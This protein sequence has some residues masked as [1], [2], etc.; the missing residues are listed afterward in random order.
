MLNDIILSSA[1]ELVRA[2]SN[3][4]SLLRRACESG[5]DCT[6]LAVR[7]KAGVKVMDGYHRLQNALWSHFV[8]VPEY[9]DGKSLQEI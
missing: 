6:E 8:S 9:N 7:P 4:N 2:N 5:G 3:K 1:Q